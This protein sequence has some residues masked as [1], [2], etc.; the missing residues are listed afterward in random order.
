MQNKYTEF[1]CIPPGGA[2]KLKYTALK[3]NKYIFN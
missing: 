3:S 2:L 1:E